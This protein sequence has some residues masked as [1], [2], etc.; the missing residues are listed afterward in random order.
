MTKKDNCGSLLRDSELAGEYVVEYASWKKRFHARHDLCVCAYENT[1]GGAGRE[2]GAYDIVGRTFDRSSVAGCLSCEC[3]EAVDLG[4]VEFAGGMVWGELRCGGIAFGPY[5][6]GH[7]AGLDDGDADALTTQF[8]P[9]T[10]AEGGE[11]EL[12]AG[13]RRHHGLRDASAD[14]ANELKAWNAATVSRHSAA[15]QWKCGA[16]EIDCAEEIDVELTT[17]I[18]WSEILE[19]PGDGDA[20]VIDQNTQTVWAGELVCVGYSRFDGGLI[21]DVEKSG[22]EV[23]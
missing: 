10:V 20:G 21:G 17:P 3:D 5:V 11:C 23:S 4:L 9:E 13:V 2:N 8:E 6:G 18:C 19:R 14:G 15:Q 16:G 22:L 1:G 12:A 7:G